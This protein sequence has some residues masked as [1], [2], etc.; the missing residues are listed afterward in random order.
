MDSFSLILTSFGVRRHGS[1]GGNGGGRATPGM[2]GVHA[3]LR[4]GDGGGGGG[5]G[6]DAGHWLQC[7]T[8]RSLPSTVAPSLVP[9]IG[10]QGALASTALPSVAG[11]VAMVKARRL[12]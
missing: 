12:K 10:W 7:H 9:V 4:Q 2:G 1:I 6:D 3:G 11:V 5:G 8:A